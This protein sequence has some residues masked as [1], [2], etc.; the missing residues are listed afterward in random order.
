METKKILGMIFSLLFIGAFAF[1]LSWGII[2][3]NKV[4]DSMSGTELYNQ[5]DLNNAYQDGYDT[6]LK[7][8]EEYTELINSYRDTI[9]TLN[10]NISH[11][12]SQITTLT[13]SNSEYQAQLASLTSQK[14]NLQTQV[15]NLNTIK[16][17][18]EAS[19]ESL[20][21]QITSLQKQ[22]TNL[23]NS[24]EDKDNQIT[25]LN[26]QISNLKTT[27]SQLQSTNDLNVSTI[28]SLNT[29]ISN[30]N[31]QISELSTLSQNSTSQINALNNK[32]NELQAS[33]NYYESYIANLE[34]GE[35]VVATFEYDNSVY[36]IQ[37]VNK[38]STLSVT[39]PTSSEY[40]IFNGW[41]VGNE[42]IDLDTYTIL[43]NTK[44]VAD[45]TY[46]YDVKFVV[47]GV[48]VDSQIVTKNNKATLPETPTKDDYDFDGWS[49]DGTNI[50]DVENATVTENVTYTA[51]FTKVH[52]V[53]FKY[54]DKTTG[55]YGVRNG[56]CATTFLGLADTNY[57]TLSGW[58]VKGVVVDH[59]NYA[60]YEDTTFEANIVY[61][62]DVIFVVDDTTYNSQIVVENGFA[63][64]PTDPEN[65]TY[66]LFNY[67][68]V[69]GEK[70]DIS[71]YK[72]TGTTTFTASF[73][74]RYDVKFMVNDSIYT[75]Q[76]VTSGSSATNPITPTLDGLT[77][78]GWSIDGETTVTVA[79]YTITENTTFI[80][81]FKE[82]EYTLTVVYNNGQAN[83]TVTQ[84]PNSTYTLT[85]PTLSGY[86]FIEWR[87]GSGEGKISGN[88]FTFGTSDTVVYAV[89]N[90]CLTT[91]NATTDGTVVHNGTSYTF[92][93]SGGS[94]GGGGLGGIA[95]CS[96]D[97]EVSTMAYVTSVDTV[98]LYC[99]TT[100]SL[101]IT[102]SGGSLLLNITTDGTYTITTNSKTSST[103][104]WSN[105]SYIT[106]S[107]TRNNV[108]LL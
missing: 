73:T 24:G 103:I 10:D 55:S 104:S 34:S 99:N 82:V 49:V 61:S 59:K 12:N 44:I 62:Y 94:I 15:D 56:E 68:T 5:E 72:I 36:N 50:V 21:N 18:N 79:S 86:E 105:A 25:Q 30:L 93:G 43:A 66:K 38:G 54:E 52:T 29:Q 13:N 35:Q 45:I 92:N 23:T 48:T 71:T 67:W 17:S 87:I 69:N 96:L 42:F 91:I 77:F 78:V 16:K 32:I 83:T 39:T 26:N 90:C 60:I 2:N 6:A 88:V 75:T 98:Q 108:V 84:L 33:V 107:V 4:K 74:N 11:V 100:D 20:N 57:K 28:T 65:T 70:V 31:A 46:K 47:D 53:T 19:I 58:K 80:G 76:I 1:V 14:E 95:F 97:D 64:A 41:K 22:V 102:I 85:T 106:I 40:K 51:L 3:F 7:D 8:K 89:Y 101:T 37:I 27:V 81:I 9:T 63:T